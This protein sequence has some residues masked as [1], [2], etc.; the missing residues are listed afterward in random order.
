MIAEKSMLGLKELIFDAEISRKTENT[1]EAHVVATLRLQLFRILIVDLWGCVFDDDRRTGSIR[2]TLREIR[3]DDKVLEALKRYY[4]DSDCLDIVV[5]GVDNH[6][7][8]ELHK[9]RAEENYSRKAIELIDSTW[10]DLDS[11]SS[12]LDTIQAKRLKWFRHKIVVH[13]EKTEHGLH[14]FEDEPPDGEGPML[15]RE[16]IDYFA[17]IRPYVYKL[18]LLITSTSWDSSSTDIERLYCKAFWDRFKNGST[19]IETMAL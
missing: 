18:F 8:I 10:N 16:P 5:E 11:N 2:S 13:Y 4:S 6:S 17:T 19:N 14:G 9:V 3:R 12:T 15:W 7:E 1:Y